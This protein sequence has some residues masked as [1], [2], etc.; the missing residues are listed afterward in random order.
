MRHQIMIVAATLELVS[1]AAIASDCASKLDPNTKYPEVLACLKAL[2]NDIGDLRSKL[3]T[4][5]AVSTL[6]VRA[7][8]AFDLPDGCPKGWARFERGASRTII[9]ARA[10]LT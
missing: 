5:T 4:A 3:A 9:G 6:P 7:V 1:T 8:V 10:R 2:E